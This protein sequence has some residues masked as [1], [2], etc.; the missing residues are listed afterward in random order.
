MKHIVKKTSAKF[1][2]DPE[3]PLRIGLMVPVNNTTME[4]E[5]LA[6]LPPGSTCIRIGIPRAKGMLTPADLP[7]YLEQATRLARELPREQI[8]LV[9][10]GCTAAGFIAGP[11]RDAEV[12]AELAAIT[13]RPVVTTASSMN[14]VLG[15]LGA[16]RIALVTP[17][18][19]AVNE[20]LKSF[21]EDAGMRV[22]AL[23]SFHASTVDELAAI[24]PA[25]IAQRA[26]E[27][28]RSGIDAMFIACSQLPT[29]AIVPELERE[30][31]I[32]VWSSIRATARE[33][34]R[35]LETALP[36]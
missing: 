4:P 7:G 14:A 34:T 19:D 5:L 25:Q 10:Y 21:I 8:D 2:S 27:T 32:P 29:R 12:A 24:T 13:S 30:L 28:A 17:Y 1:E 18:L 22:E 15:Q 26:R 16:K 3:R 36:R 23:S 9:V 6:W 33:A 31:G 35:A 11:R 20:R